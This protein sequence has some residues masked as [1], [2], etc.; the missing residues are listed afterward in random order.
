LALRLGV[1][2]FRRGDLGIREAA[3]EAARLARGSDVRAQ[4]ALPTPKSILWRHWMPSAADSQ[5]R[6]LVT[7]VAL[8]DIGRSGDHPSHGARVAG[9]SWCCQSPSGRS[10]AI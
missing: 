9:S 4:R 6:V 10:S 8:S 1:Y 5:I 2:H 7:R 3:S